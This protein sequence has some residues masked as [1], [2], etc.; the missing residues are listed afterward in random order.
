MPNKKIVPNVVTYNA[1]VDGHIK[2]WQHK[3]PIKVLHGMLNKVINQNLSI[4]KID[5]PCLKFIHLH[6]FGLS[7]GLILVRFLLIL[8]NIFKTDLYTLTF[9]SLC[10]HFMSMALPCIYTPVLH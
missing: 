2:E 5:T 6:Y 4:R 10:F 8:W 9:P 1:F 7:F 3:E